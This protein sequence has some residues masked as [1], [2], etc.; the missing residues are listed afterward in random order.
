[1]QVVSTQNIQV[2]L[3]RFS[4]MKKL[5]PRGRQPGD[6][7]G[8]AGKSS[9]KILEFFFKSSVSVLQKLAAVSLICF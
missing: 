1:M 2:K 5:P 9:D 3:L 8:N 7:L 6:L 4:E